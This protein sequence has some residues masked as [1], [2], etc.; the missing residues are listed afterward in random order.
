LKISNPILENTM[1]AI[2]CTLAILFV[3][4]TTLGCDHSTNN[5]PAP[6][7]TGVTIATPASDSYVEGEVE[8][9]LASKGVAVDAV[10]FYVDGKVIESRRSAPWECTWNTAG[11]PSNSAHTIRAVA[12]ND[13]NAYTSSQS[14]VVRI[15]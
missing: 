9:T 4:L 5:E 12:Y 8:I 2:T 14:V 6:S 3:A 11:L 1:K 13:V 7:G 10:D 15:K